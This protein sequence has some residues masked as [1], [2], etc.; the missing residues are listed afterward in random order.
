MVIIPFQVVAFVVVN[1][2]PIFDQTP[3][4]FT[5]T[6]EPIVVNTLT[7]SAIDGNEDPVDKFKFYHF[8]DIN[9]HF[10]VMTNPEDTELIVKG[11][12]VN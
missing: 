6:I 8:N 1:E 11:F 3:E 2:Q 4:T 12:Y 10:L 7:V 5:W 9:L